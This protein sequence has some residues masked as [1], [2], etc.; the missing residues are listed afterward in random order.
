MKKNR[1]WSESFGHALD[2]IRNTARRERNFRI[3]TAFAVLAI[4]LCI[5]FRV[6][7]WQFMLVVTA[8]FFVLATE[9]VNTAV[10]AAVDLSCGGRL[11]PL[12]KVAK[13]AAAGAVLLAAAFAVIVGVVV[14]IDIARTLIL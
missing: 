8:I 12:A 2:G 1:S 4:A 7:M 10:E 6:E 5:I 13:D 11:H 9:L 14:T 3:Q